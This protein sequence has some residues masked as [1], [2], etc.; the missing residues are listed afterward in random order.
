MLG[1]IILDIDLTLPVCDFHPVVKA[2]LL[3]QPFQIQ[4]HLPTLK[5]FHCKVTPSN[6]PLRLEIWSQLPCFLHINIIF[7]RGQTLAFPP[8]HS[9]PVPPSHHCTKLHPLHFSP[10]LFQ[11]LQNCSSCLGSFIYWSHPLSVWNPYCIMLMSKALH[12]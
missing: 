12:D 3:A 6:H 9:C 8:L 11:E 4:S 10:R 1:R 7:M 5:S 2:C